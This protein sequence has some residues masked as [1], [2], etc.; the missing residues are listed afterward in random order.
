[1]P[2][3]KSTQLASAKRNLKRIQEDEATFRVRI[4]GMSNTEQ[5]KAIEWFYSIL[6]QQQDYVR[7]LED[8]NLPAD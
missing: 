4:Q 8:S 7:Q 3:S 6:K 5:E 1:V 2:Q